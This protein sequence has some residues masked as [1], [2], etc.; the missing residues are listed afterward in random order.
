MKTSLRKPVALLVLLGV[1]AVLAWGLWQATRPAPELL[2]GQMEARETDIAGKVTARV[3]DVAVR[4]G[5]RIERGALLVRLDSPEV[6]AKLQQATAAEQAA[7]AD[8]RPRLAQLQ[9]RLHVRQA[10]DVQAGLTLV[11]CL[12]SLASSAACC[13]KSAMRYSTSACLRGEKPIIGHS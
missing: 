4:E 8:G 1:L 6:R 5:E 9:Q 13:S 10:L 2:Q 11:V 7:Q 12:P 3:L